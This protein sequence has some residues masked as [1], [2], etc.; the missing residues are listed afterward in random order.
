MKQFKNK[1]I[2][3]LQKTIKSKNPNTQARDNIAETAKSSATHRQINNH[4][5]A[6]SYMLW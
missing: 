2:K 4:E 6:M 3:N 1:L 5:I